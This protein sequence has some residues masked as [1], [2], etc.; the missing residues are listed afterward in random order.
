M[1]NF[2]S[3]KLIELGSCAFRQ[4][5]ATSH[6][7]KIHGYQLL[8][9]FYF[10]AFSLDEK[11]WVV[12]FASLKTLKSILQHQFDHTL[13]VAQDDP[14]IETFQ[15]LHSQGGCDLRIMESVGIEKTAEF[16][17][18]AAT[19]WLKENYGERCWVEKVE[20]FEHEANSAIYVKPNVITHSL[21]MPSYYGG[22]S[23][24]N[25]VK[26]TNVDTLSEAN[27]PSTTETN[28][29]PTETPAP[30]EVQPLPEP[31]V[32]QT[33][34]RVGRGQVTQGWSNPFGGT[35]WGV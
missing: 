5:R 28:V 27:I 16:C 19:N 8:A 3:T 34:A 26:N 35:S 15:L 6:C 2:Q 1:S 20:V 22:V 21:Q 9:K 4:W 33:G 17:F 11:N 10:A 32:P 12:D 23:L 30:I 24:L 13:C 31:P 14:L 25:E 7:S 18:N 29:K